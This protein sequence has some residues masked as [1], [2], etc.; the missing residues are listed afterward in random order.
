VSVGDP[1]PY[2]CFKENIGKI[3]KL[4]INSWTEGKVVLS[5]QGIVSTIEFENE[6]SQVVS[7]SITTKTENSQDSVIHKE[8]EN[9]MNEKC[10]E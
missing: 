9:I 6:N 3:S 8:I 7:Y 4:G 1:I 5:G 2:S 10:S